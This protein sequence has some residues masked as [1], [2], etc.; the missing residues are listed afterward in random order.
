MEHKKIS[1]MQNE[2]LKLQPLHVW[3]YFGEI[4]QIPHP[5]KKEEKMIAYLLETGKKLGL[6]T[7]RD[8]AGNVLISKPATQGKENVT[9]VVFQSHIDMVCEKNAD[10]VFNFDTDAIQPYIDGEWVKAKGTTLG[11]DDG[12]GMAIQL[13]LL[14]D[15][16]IEHGPIEC[17]F[18][19]DEET[20]LTGAFAL[21][22]GF[23][24]GKMLLNLDSEDEGQFFIG[25]AGGKDTI[26]KIDYQKEAVPAGMKAFSISVKGLK[27]G[28]SGD[29]INKG[30][31]N[32]NKILNRILFAGT[33]QFDIAISH[34][35]SGNLRNA[36]AREGNAVVL[37]PEANSGK[38][39]QFV[40]E[41]AKTVKSELCVTDSG[42]EVSIAPTEM[43]KFVIGDF[44]Q[45]DL[46]DAVYACPHGVLAMS[47]DIKDFVETSTNLA[48]I[49]M[50][51]TQIIVTT[52]QRSSV[53]SKKDDACNMVA[54]LFGLIDA[55][56]EHSDGYPGWNPNPKSEV[57][58]VLKQAYI[59][60]F[61]KEPQVL[62]IHAGL[63]CGL[64]AE[65]YPDLD[66]ISYGPTLRGVHSPDEKLLI[67]SVQQVW[68]LTVEFLRILR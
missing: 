23:M 13:A 3:K 7:K 39:M 67:E 36:I 4:C 66:M 33:Y 24:T 54:S 48:S 44:T 34:I 59:N 12:I 11:A 46:V 29:D 68:D 58:N 21:E 28:H 41:F 10:T 63:E 65:K 19:V 5:S 51:D 9:P 37:V 32:A 52:S 49:K 31:G 8:K 38:F 40:E 45:S 18:T 35:D 22:A 64:F 15:K 14:E 1:R 61:N 57:L 53:E 42:V 43:P 50:T 30:L 17:L 27:G 60:L 47:Q 2:I 56:I 20:G 26:V 16:T 55:D 25:C 62:A 6:E